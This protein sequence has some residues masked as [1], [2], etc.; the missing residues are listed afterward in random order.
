MSEIVTT[1]KIKNLDTL[2][3]KVNNSITKQTAN[4]VST[5]I[6]GAGL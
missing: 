1:E 6:A 2:Y 3:S 4:L 5:E